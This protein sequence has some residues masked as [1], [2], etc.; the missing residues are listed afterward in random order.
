MRFSVQWVL[1]RPRR[2]VRSFGMRYRY[3]L[4][5]RVNTSGKSS[6]LQALAIEHAL[7]FYFLDLKELITIEQLRLLLKKTCKERCLL[8]IEDAESCFQPKRLPRVPD[9]LL[10]T[11][12]AAQLAA[13][14][15]GA[16]NPALAGGGA[17]ATSKAGT[18]AGASN[19]CLSVQAIIVWAH[20]M[21]MPHLEAVQ[22]R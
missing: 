1:G 18:N 7:K 20:D 17:A 6:T 19:T 3:A 14:T 8:V 15:Q 12:A 21:L 13:A 5:M 16:F 9:Q 11:A 4:A 22:T 10:G 2:P